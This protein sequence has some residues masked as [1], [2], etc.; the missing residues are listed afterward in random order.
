MKRVLLYVL[1]IILPCTALSEG[2]GYAVVNNPNP[3]DRLNLRSQPD[4]DSPSLGKY[5][6]GTCVTVL[7]EADGWTHVSAGETEG[8]M[9]SSFLAAPDAPVVPMTIQM[10]VSNPY[11]DVQ[12]L[13]SSTGP[14]MQVMV[15]I[16]NG[17]LVTAFGYAGE[18]MHVQYGGLTGYM[19]RACLMDW[20]QTTEAWNLE[21]SMPIPEALQGT[22]TRALLRTGSGEWELTDASALETLSAL[23][24]SREHWGQNRAGCLFGAQLLL[25]FADGTLQTIELATDGCCIYRH[26]G[27]DFRYAANAEEGADSRLLFCL[28]EGFTGE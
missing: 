24:G 25:E 9:M 11:A 27:H 6:N 8:Y 21:T 28:F 12:G 26:G 13:L 15:F 14:E 22:L 3:S 16:P 10:K 20:M 1:L 19:P 17:V 18:Y 2:W 5:L 23:L 7:E 4:A